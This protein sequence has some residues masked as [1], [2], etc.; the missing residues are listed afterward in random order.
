MK[1]T[2]PRSSNKRFQLLSGQFRKI[3]ETDV[4]LEAGPPLAKRQRTNRASNEHESSVRKNRPSLGHTYDHSPMLGSLKGTNCASTG[5][6]DWEFDIQ[7]DTL[8]KAPSV[9]LIPQ[10]SFSRRG[11]CTTVP[12]RHLTED[13]IQDSFQERPSSD[14]SWLQGTQNTLRMP[15]NY[16]GYESV[17]VELQNQLQ[18]QRSEIESLRKLNEDLTQHS[19]KDAPKHLSPPWLTVHRVQY[20][21]S[22]R[23][24]EDCPQWTWTGSQYRIE[25]LRP[26][27][28]LKK[29]VKKRK[30]A[31]TA[32]LVFHSYDLSGLQDYEP[33]D[34]HDSE[35]VDNFR[36]STQIQ[37]LNPLL[38]GA[39][40][41]LLEQN[42]ILK[43]NVNYGGCLDLYDDMDSDNGE[44]CDMVTNIDIVFYHFR[45]FLEKAPNEFERAEG[46]TLQHFVNYLIEEFGEKHQVIEQSFAEGLVTPTT[47]KYLFKRED[48]VVFCEDKGVCGA[49]LKSFSE[50]P[51]HMMLITAESY[52]FDGKFYLQEKESKLC[53][54][55]SMRE[56]QSTEINSLPCYPIS[57][58]DAEVKERLRKRGHTFWRCRQL[59]YVAYNGPNTK[60]DTN[61]VG[62]LTETLLLCYT[63]SNPY[64]QTRGF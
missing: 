31:E 64:R 54:P 63:K 6:N 45:D 15:S 27:P 18:Q 37:F 59:A 19:R 35:L 43:R 10:S 11:R 29:F 62:L 24:Y 12:V 32:F 39:F 38:S 42:D 21:G 2:K 5:L 61:Y 1:N 46:Q 9:G 17:Y 8:P 25:G 14:C 41:E 40:D 33:S 52:A 36:T 3:A 49:K 16:R 28:R 26:I 58:A 23:L 20:S 56:K 4:S 53:L 51:K 22:E 7:R 34:H 47:L 55:H 44:S 57:F 30:G 60:Q 48:I 50:A 13:F